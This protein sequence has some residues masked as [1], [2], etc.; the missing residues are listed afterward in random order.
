MPQKWTCLSLLFKKEILTEIW[1]QFRVYFCIVWWS[2]IFYLKIDQMPN[3]VLHRRSTFHSTEILA[4]FSI[5]INENIWQF[6]AIFRLHLSA[7]ILSSLLPTI[8]Q[9]TSL[10][11]DTARFAPYDHISSKTSCLRTVKGICT[12]TNDTLMAH[13]CFYSFIRYY[14]GET[15]LLSVFLAAYYLYVWRCHIVKWW[16][17]AGGSFSG[18]YKVVPAGKVST[19]PWTATAMC[20]IQPQRKCSA[21]VIWTS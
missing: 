18:W 1:L 14:F 15:S 16:R 19:V 13:V 6:F 4:S 7:L 2:T 10:R 8:C 3:S 9:K 21:S 17:K 11:F 12:T 20:Y 5:N